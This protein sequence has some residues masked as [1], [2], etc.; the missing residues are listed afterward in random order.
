MG[1]MGWK[2][3]EIIV[4][5]SVSSGCD[6]I[7]NITKV[8]ITGFCEIGREGLVGFEGDVRNGYRGACV[9]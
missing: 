6:A 2:I 9:T 3:L 8:L 5:Q 7:G 4:A 1:G